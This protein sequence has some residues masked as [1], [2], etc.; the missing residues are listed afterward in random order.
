[1]TPPEPRTPLALG[2]AWASRITG[3]GLEVALPAMGGY[4]LDGWWGTRPWATLAG[5]ALGFVL[6]FIHLLQ[7]ARGGLKP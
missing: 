6:G 1:V 3:F 5:A 2:M 4:F 7:T